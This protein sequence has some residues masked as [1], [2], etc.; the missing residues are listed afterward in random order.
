MTTSSPKKTFSLNATNEKVM[1]RQPCAM[2]VVC[3]SLTLIVFHAGS[4]LADGCNATR[5]VRSDDTYPD[6]STKQRYPRLI[7]FNT[8]D[9]GDVTVGAGVRFSLQNSICFMV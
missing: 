1:S 3:Y 5:R 6:G 9:D 7:T 4:T 2:K 8:Q